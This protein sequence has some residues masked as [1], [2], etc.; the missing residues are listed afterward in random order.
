[1]YTRVPVA[2][3]VPGEVQDDQSH[4]PEPTAIDGEEVSERIP[5]HEKKEETVGFVQRG[6]GVREKRK[7]G[8]SVVEARD[9]MW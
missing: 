4:N 9:H 5:V 8:D 7:I 1:M 6:P 2:D 3:P